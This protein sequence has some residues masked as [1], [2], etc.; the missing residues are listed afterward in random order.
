MKKIPEKMT[1]KVINYPLI[2]HS[3]LNKVLEVIKELQVIKS[4]K[5]GVYL[6]FNNNY[7]CKRLSVKNKYYYNKKG[8]VVNKVEGAQEE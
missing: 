8:V 6:S 3:L 1:L 2:H 4:N 5:A 7:F